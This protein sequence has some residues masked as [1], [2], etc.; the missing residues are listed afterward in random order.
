MIEI[1]F[2]KQTYICPYCGKQQSYSSGI[3]MSSECV[4][5]DPAGRRHFEETMANARFKY[6]GS[7]LF[8]YQ[9]KCSNT[10]CNKIISVGKF[11]VSKKQ[12]DIMP[13][14]VHRTFPDYIPEQIRNDYYEATNII[15]LSPKA[16][17]TL[18]RRCLQGM[19]HHFWGIYGK[20]LNAEITTLQG[21]VSPSLWKALDGLRKMGNIG[22]H[23]ENDVNLIVDIDSNETKKLQKLIELLF[24]KWYIAKHDEEELFNDINN[25]SSEKEIERKGNTKDARDER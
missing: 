5:F 9:I 22:A 18:L 21:K 6:D 15:D 8:V 11:L 17:A 24:D 10:Q 1:D 3:N 25:I 2:D 20:N 19:I 4:Y 7:E 13:Q 12:I 14:Y 16:A 23:M